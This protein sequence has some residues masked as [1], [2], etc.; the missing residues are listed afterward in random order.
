MFVHSRSRS[1]LSSVLLAAHCALSLKCISLSLCVFHIYLQGIRARSDKLLNRIEAQFVC[2]V[3]MCIDIWS[4]RLANTPC[5]WLDDWLAYDRHE[6]LD[7]DYDLCF[8]IKHLI[9]FS[10]SWFL[11]NFQSL[12]LQPPLPR[13]AS[14]NSER[15]IYTDRFLLKKIFFHVKS[16]KSVKSKSKTT[17]KLAANVESKLIK[18]KVGHSQTSN[19]NTNYNNRKMKETERKKL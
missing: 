4:T 19:V 8:D 11:M 9:K 13:T 3:L 14:M 2:L 16:V 15:T 7:D 10:S 1:T 12:K 6:M 17:F 18:S 5:G